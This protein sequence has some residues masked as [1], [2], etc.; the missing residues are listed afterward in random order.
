MRVLKKVDKDRSQET[1]ISSATYK[2]RQYARG[3]VKNPEIE[4]NCKFSSAAYLINQ[5]N[6]LG[7]V[8]DYATTKLF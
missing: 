7:V 4:L 5:R 2:S 6:T 8:S 3:C 1:T